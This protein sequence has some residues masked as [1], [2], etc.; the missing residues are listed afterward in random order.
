MQ[1]LEFSGAV[2]LL[3]RSLGV[4]RLDTSTA[5][6]FPLPYTTYI[7]LY[8]Q[9]LLNSNPTMLSPNWIAVSLRRFTVYPEAGGR[10]FLRNI[11]NYQLNYGLQTC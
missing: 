11:C 9:L 7:S 3:Y 10:R 1:R 6:S 4:K 5:F 8:T 2:R